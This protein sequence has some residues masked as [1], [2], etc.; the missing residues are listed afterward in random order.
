MPSKT[1][2]Q[3]KFMRAAC[4]DKKIAD[5][6]HISQDVACEFVKADLAKARGEK[7]K[8]ANAHGKVAKESM[9]VTPSA[10]IS[11]TG[12]VQPNGTPPFKTF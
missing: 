6:H 4:H 11:S 7:P 5:A 8:A 3:A 12:Y 10:S 9:S 1:P 2:E